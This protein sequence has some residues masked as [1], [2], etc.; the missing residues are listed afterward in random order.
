MVIIDPGINCLDFFR[1][2]ISPAR[3]TPFPPKRMPTLVQWGLFDP[4]KPLDA[5]TLA[6]PLILTYR[7]FIHSNWIKIFHIIFYKHVFP[8]A[9][10]PSFRS[11]FFW[12][13][14]MFEWNRIAMLVL[15]LIFFCPKPSVRSIHTDP[16]SALRRQ[17]SHPPVRPLRVRQWVGTGWSLP[18]ADK[19]A[20]QPLPPLSCQPFPRQ[21][22]VSGSSQIKLFGCQLFGRSY[23]AILTVCD[24]FFPSPMYSPSWS[25]GSMPPPP[26]RT[27]LIEWL[28]SC[29]IFDS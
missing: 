17:R 1:S 10:I 5:P 7:D 23:R 12:S 2:K 21:K 26:P 4:N 3:C 20:N 25:H 14:N 6:C 13:Q 11:C 9:F 19:T 8:V 27:L 24:S 22:V 29:S 15:I 28:I 18:A 16:A